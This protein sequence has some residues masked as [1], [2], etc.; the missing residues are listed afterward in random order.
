MGAVGR[1]RRGK[2][3]DSPSFYS[4]WG[5]FE[6]ST[7]SFHSHGNTEEHCL[8]DEETGVQRSLLPYPGSRSYYGAEPTLNWAPGST[9]SSSE[10]GK[11]DR[12]FACVLSLLCSCSVMT[13]RQEF[14]DTVPRAPHGP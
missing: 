10:P 8:T 6:R 13:S 5:T 12:E 11:R 2:S 1:G 3:Q 14:A 4:G 7:I 9:L